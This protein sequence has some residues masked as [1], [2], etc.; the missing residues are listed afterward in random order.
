MLAIRKHLWIAALLFAP[1]VESQDLTNL[2]GDLT[3][4]SPLSIALELPAP[5]VDS[6][7]LIELHLEA[8]GDFH[9]SFEADRVGRKLSLGPSFNHR[10]CGGCHIR[11]GK[12]AIKFSTRP[13]GSPLLVKVALRGLNKNGAPKDVPGVGEQLQDHLVSGKSQFDIRLRYSAVGGSYPD[14][15]KYTLRRPQLTFDIPGIDEKNV[16]TSLR[17]TPTVIGMGL[18]EGVPDA[19]LLAMADPSDAD[20]DGISGEVNYVP[21]RETKTMAI[22]RFGFRASHPTVKQQSAAAF[23]H[24]MGLTNELFQKRRTPQEISP[25]LLAKVQFYLQAAGVTPA[26]DQTDPDVIAGKALFQQVNCSGCHTMTLSTGVTSVAATTNQVFHPF[27]DL[28]L[29]D[30][31]PGLADGRAEFSAS[32]REWRTTPLWG[33]GLTDVLAP[34]VKPGFLHDGRARSIEEAILWHGGEATASRDA[35]K[36]LP[37]A[38]RDQLIRFLRSL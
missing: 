28:L 21:D 30:M 6:Q 11:N 27:T 14:G 3:S 13:P 1:P 29:H 18:L 31:G 16:V 23:F 36:A 7:E 34:R 15:T 35:F 8:H 24:D 32:G 26:R 12:G 9:R 33:I 2:G 17:M 19:T 10:S 25:E 38:Q 4:D 22:G 20:G 5:N 37:Q